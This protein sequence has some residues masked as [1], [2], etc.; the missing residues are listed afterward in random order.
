MGHIRVKCRGPITEKKNIEG[1]GPVKMSLMPSWPDVE[2]AFVDDEG[3]EHDITGVTAIHW[4]AKQGS[5]IPTCRVEVLGVEIDAE[6]VLPEVQPVECPRCK[7]TGDHLED[8][9]DENVEH[10]SMCNGR[11][12]VTIRSVGPREW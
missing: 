12:V 8:R 1:V 10:C 11:K 6:G 2:I 5:E 9:F 7:G 3:A 4:D